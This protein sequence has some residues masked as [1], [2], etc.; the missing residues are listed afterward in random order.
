IHQSAMGIDVLLASKRPK[1]TFSIDPEF[2]RR[3]FAK[4]RKEYDYIILDT[5]LN[6]LD[7]LLAQVCYPIADRIIYV[8][9]PVITSA[10]SMTR[11]I[12]EVTNPTRRNGLD[13]PKTNIGIVISKFPK[14]DPGASHS[15]G[16]ERIN[17]SP[18]G[19]P[20]A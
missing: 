1:H 18:Q 10:W 20:I 5:S 11:W 15:F 16:P 7:P 2:Y 12:L 17:R 3:L 19:I 8:T 6:Y 14:Q 4:L 13:I 9:E